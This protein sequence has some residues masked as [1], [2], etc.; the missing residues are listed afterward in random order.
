MIN[1]LK[2][3]LHSANL[4][5]VETFIF[6]FTI[7][8]TS[9]SYPW[10]I[11]FLFLFLFL[12]F[13]PFSTIIITHGQFIFL[14]ISFYIYLFFKIV[15]FT[16]VQKLSLMQNNTF[17]ARVTSWKID[18]LCISYHSGKTGPSQFHIN[19]IKKY[20]LYLSNCKTQTIFNLF[21]Y[22][23]LKISTYKCY[24]WII[25]LIVVIKYFSILQELD[26]YLKQHFN[27]HK[28]FF[29]VCYFCLLKLL[30]TTKT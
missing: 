24:A 20:K 23:S 13:Y 7:T 30:N 3:F 14:I 16:L 4:A 10:S 15:F 22:S 2:I 26:Y 21:F 9:N 29:N 19:E 1:S 8:V 27:T 5:R 6:F 28:Y 11:T 12:F 25:K 18:N 17:R